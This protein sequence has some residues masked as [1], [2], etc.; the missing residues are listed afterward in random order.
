[1]TTAALTCRHRT[2]RSERGIA[3]T[4]AR[5]YNQSDAAQLNTIFTSI[6]IDILHGASRLV[7]DDTP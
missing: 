4:P 1:V 6:A 7:D 2:R 3:S 5:F